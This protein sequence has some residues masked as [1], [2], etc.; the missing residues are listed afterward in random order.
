MIR[1]NNPLINRDQIN[2]YKLILIFF[3]NKLLV[4]FCVFFLLILG[5]AYVIFRPLELKTTIVLDDPAVVIFEKY[6]KYFLNENNIVD[7]PNPNPNININTNTNTNTNTSIARDIFLATYR[8]NFLSID[9]LNEFTKLVIKSDINLKNYHKKKDLIYS[10]FFY[11][12]K[13][14]RV[15]IDKRLSFSSDQVFFLIYPE[16]IDGSK[17]L[18]DYAYY[19][20]KKT[21]IDFYKLVRLAISS[22]IDS[23]KQALEI[24]KK[25]NLNYLKNSKSSASDPNNS[26]NNQLSVYLNYLN[27]KYVVLVE[28]IINL[29]KDLISIKEIDLN[30]EPVLE[31]PS[32]PIRET[33]FPGY[34]I[35][36]SSILLGFFISIIIIL[37]R[38]KKI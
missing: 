3:K 38:P 19:I 7:N 28:E 32:P 2:L 30:Y 9:N 26:F 23:K 24:V 1:K 34:F 33:K 35:I 11:K 37:F 10:S 13:F 29:E 21:E 14:G 12:N 6:N 25:L 4:F 5:L 15:N 20:K 27:N 22:K 18:S 8:K 31:K 17:I 36:I 16:D